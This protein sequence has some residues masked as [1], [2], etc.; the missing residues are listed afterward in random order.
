[1]THP[2]VFL[3]VPG[4]R[5][6]L[7]QLERILST[8]DDCRGVRAFYRAATNVLLVQLRLGAAHHTLGAFAGLEIRANGVG[9]VLFDPGRLPDRD[10]RSFFDD[11]LA[12]YDQ[13]SLELLSPDEMAQTIPSLLPRLGVPLTAP[14]LPHLAMLD[15]RFRRGDSWLL[16]RARSLSREGVYVTA[17]TPPRKG[18]VV[19]LQLALRGRTTLV[20]G[21]VLQVTSHDALTNSGAAGFGVRFLC[22]GQAVGEDALHEILECALRQHDHVPPAP[23]PRR[24]VRYPVRWPVCVGSPEGALRLWALDLSSHGMFL[25]HVGTPPRAPLRLS[26]PG[27]DGHGPI[28]VT[29]RVAREIPS[30][31]ARARKV[32]RGFGLELLDFV[33]SDE[34]RFRT[35]LSRVALRT[36]RYV[37]VGAAPMRV[38]E[39]T[40]ALASAGYTASGVTSVSTLLTRA[41]QVGSNDLVLLC[42]SLQ[43][44]GGTRSLTQALA[45]KKVRTLCMTATQLPADARALADGALL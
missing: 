38:T 8:V 43:T 26:L 24:D 19:D 44:P 36:E 33:P 40:T 21:S 29:A 25:A 28:R 22:G 13:C 34:A 1:M 4:L 27:D 20:K 17:S 42:T 32:P 23:P 37:V 11:H 15:I 14:S 7:A 35:L 18:E 9:A 10:R 31:V 2:D 12:L 3:V 5:Q 39:I 30:S 6:R 16:G 45:G 41:S